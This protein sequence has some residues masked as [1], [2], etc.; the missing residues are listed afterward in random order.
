MVSATQLSSYLYCPR[1]LFISKVLLVEEPPKEEL[2]KGT[3][4]HKTY[5]FIN[6]GEEKIV[7][8]LRTAAYQD[9]YDLYRTGFS[10]FLRNAIVQ[11]KTEL[12][13]FNIDLAQL[14]HDYWPHFEEEAKQ[15]A[16]HVAEFIKEHKIFGKELWDALTP[17][18]L[19]EQYFKS[20]P[21]NLSGIIDMIEVHKRP[22]GSELYVPVELKTGAVP[23]T[24]MWEGHRL[25]LGC[26]VLLLQESGKSASEGILRYKG[27]DNPRILVMN[28]LLRDE[29]LDLI[30]KVSSILSSFEIPD[31]VD[32]KNKCT[33]C[34][35]KEDC[36][37]DQKMHELIE[38]AKKRLVV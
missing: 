16:L 22:D 10:K 1:K 37:N 4:W 6:T 32:N 15:R 7:T 20:D 23:R 17:K 21:L 14:F 5:E 38:E 34:P 9:I 18:I 11:S 35:F 19:S 8:A 24:G 27:S 25:Q 30:Q 28:P 31:K 2:I 26:Y 36:Y 13:K 29:I 3:V 12:Q 33:K